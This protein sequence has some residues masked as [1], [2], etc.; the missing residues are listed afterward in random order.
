MKAFPNHK[1]LL[2]GQTV[3]FLSGFVGVFLDYTIPSDTSN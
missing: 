2:E 1:E 3:M